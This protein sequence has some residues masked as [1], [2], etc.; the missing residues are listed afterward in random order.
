M[1]H[2]LLSLVLIS[3]GL[4]LKMNEKESK[5]Y[6]RRGMGSFFLQWMPVQAEEINQKWFHSGS[7]LQLVT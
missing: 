5:K 6:D 1:I 2:G 7:S 4:V 3:H